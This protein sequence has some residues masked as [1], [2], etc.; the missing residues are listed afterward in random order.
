M[1]PKDLT[2][3]LEDLRGVK[4]SPKPD[5]LRQ[6]RAAAAYDVVFTLINSRPERAAVRWDM[7]RGLRFFIDP[8]AAKIGRF[9]SLSFKSQFLYYV[10]VPIQPR[11]TKGQPGSFYTAD[12]LPHLINAFEHYLVDGASVNPT[13][14]LIAY[15]PPEDQHPLRLR[16]IRKLG[17]PDAFLSPRWGGVQAYNIEPPRNRTDGPVPHDMDMRK[18]RF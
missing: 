13:L 16:E 7:T 15:I 6:F 10:D 14:H 18:V 5:R 12:D 11:R 17:L 8:L 1:V 4:A 2:A 9:V 3:G